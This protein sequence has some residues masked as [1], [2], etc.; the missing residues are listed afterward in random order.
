MYQ[1]R[2]ILLADVLRLKSLLL[3]LETERQGI[4]NQV[5]ALQGDVRIILND[6]A[7]F[8]YLPRIDESR[9]DTVFLRLLHSTK[10]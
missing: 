8:V 6:T 10:R 4:V 1:K 2:S 3:S 7:G 5:Y 9:L